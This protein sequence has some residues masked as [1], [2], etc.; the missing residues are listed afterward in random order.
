MGEN[1]WAIRSSEK[2]GLVVE[3]TLRKAVRF[4]RRL[5]VEKGMAILR[6]DWEVLV[7]RVL[8][9]KPFEVVFNELTCH[10]RSKETNG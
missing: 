4:Q 9:T 8:Q 6:E 3:G 5:V 2:A 10:T 7:Y 1:R